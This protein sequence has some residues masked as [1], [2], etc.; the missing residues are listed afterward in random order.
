MNYQPENL[1][2]WTMPDSYFGAEWRDYYSSGCGQSRD[3][4]ALE[5][6]NF[7]CMLRQLGG[8]S[9]TVVIVRENHWAVG[10]IEWIAIHQDDGKALQIADEL[11]GALSDYPVIDES[12]WSELE[13]EDANEVW[14]NATMTPDAWPIS[15]NFARNLNSAIMST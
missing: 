8:E 2:R 11:Q 6:S 7:I 15:A 12:H 1:Q 14:T 13:Q 5:R 4:D 10:W 3:S 9:D